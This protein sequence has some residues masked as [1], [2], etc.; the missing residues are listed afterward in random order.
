[1][2]V[3][4]N[5][6]PV[7]A[8]QK[9]LLAWHGLR[10]RVRQWTKAELVPRMVGFD[11]EFS[12]ARKECRVAPQQVPVAVDGLKFVNE[13]RHLCHTSYLIPEDY[14]A[15]VHNVLYC[16]KNGA[17]LTNDGRFLR[18]SI[19]T[20]ETFYRNWK[21]VSSDQLRSPR[22]L[23]GYAT[24]LRSRY[25]NHY[26]TLLDNLP[27]LM[28]ISRPPFTDLAKIKLLYDGTL[29]DLEAFL[30]PKLLPSNVQLVQVELDALIRLESL[31]F[32]PFK[33]RNYAGYLPR[34]YV[35][36]FRSSVFPGRPPRADRRI[37]IKRSG[38]TGRRGLENEADVL[39]ALASLGFRG[40]VLENLS[41]KEQVD[42]FYDAEVVIGVHG[43]GLANLLFTPHCKVVELFS[44][45]AVVPHYFFLCASLGHEYTCVVGDRYSQN[46]PCRVDINRLLGHLDRL[47]I[48]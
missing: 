12:S 7:I 31:L 38:A 13:A 29:S 10:A 47:G 25:N 5:F 21:P 45:V 4:S 2:D 9:G 42:L 24:I 15:T 33:T 11:E 37:I 22:Y 23:D 19:S 18:E 8:K 44:T 39:R 41:F 27:R 48:R 14:V 43:A 26:H 20:A 1:M 34:C 40:Y 46:A 36:L 32:T 16:P 6:T 17:I 30:L 28:A 35:D 3:V